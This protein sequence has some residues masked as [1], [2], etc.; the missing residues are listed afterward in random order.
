MRPK[1]ELSSQQVKS[2]L[3]GYESYSVIMARKFTLWI[4]NISHGHRISTLENRA[5]HES[6]T[7]PIVNLTGFVH[8]NCR[9]FFHSFV[10]FHFL[11]DRRTIDHHYLMWE[12]VLSL[13]SRKSAYELLIDSMIK[14]N[15]IG[16]WTELV[17]RRMASDTTRE[18]FRSLLS[19]TLSCVCIEGWLK[20]VIDSSILTPDDCGAIHVRAS[21]L[22]HRAQS[23]FWPYL[24]DI[25]Y[26][27]IVED[28]DN[29]GGTS[30]LLAKCTTS[31]EEAVCFVR[32]QGHPNHSKS[33]PDGQFGNTLDM[34]L[35][36]GDVS[37]SMCH[38]LAGGMGFSSLIYLNI[39]SA[40]LPS[41]AI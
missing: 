41:V 18:G 11:Y 28:L 1:Y 32:A 20:I 38:K 9:T 36:A 3:P 39:T 24:M 29:Q 30:R 5:L 12:E 16:P 6:L 13:G 10:Y 37:S 33:Q 17:G 35:Y 25:R 27:K 8:L 2:G 22:L 31:E 15:L 34:S 26:A 40:I 23:V 19:H 21:Y 14:C 4:K 7:A